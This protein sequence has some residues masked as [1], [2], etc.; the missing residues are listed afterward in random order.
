MILVSWHRKL[1]TLKAPFKAVSVYHQ[2]IAS[3]I[4]LE[5]KNLMWVMNRMKISQEIWK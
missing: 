5:Y 3:M 4:A 2:K 1:K